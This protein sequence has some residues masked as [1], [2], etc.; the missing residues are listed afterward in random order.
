M[1]NMKEKC[2]GGGL[3]LLHG[4]EHLQSFASICKLYN[5]RYTMSI[6]P[7]MGIIQ[8]IV[9]WLISTSVFLEPDYCV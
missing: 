4:S 5:K 6:I 7:Y 9:C 3:P 2:Q 1:Q 8:Y